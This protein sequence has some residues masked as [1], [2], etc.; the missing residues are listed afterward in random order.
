MKYIK[1]T[2]NC[3]S[4]KYSLELIIYY[5]GF[6]LVTSPIQILFTSL[7]F[8][9]HEHFGKKATNRIKRTTDCNISFHSPKQ[10]NTE[11][12][13][14]VQDIVFISVIAAFI[15]KITSVFPAL[16]GRDV[17]ISANSNG[18]FSNQP[19]FIVMFCTN[20]LLNAWITQ[21]NR[22]RVF[23]LPASQWCT[24]CERVNDSEL[25][26][27]V[28]STHSLLGKTSKCWGIF[29]LPCCGYKRL[30]P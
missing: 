8:S 10:Q 28:P 29:F 25:F 19:D 9:T 4:F 7:F 14:N 5:Y 13:N 17:F 26:F 2:N 20:P 18:A 12:T 16:F 27:L 22:I 6:A 3:S 11:E 1:L 24:L 23:P 21:L 15:Q 30:E